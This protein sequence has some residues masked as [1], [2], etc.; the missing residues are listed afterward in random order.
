MTEASAD[1]FE[2]I[3]ADAEFVPI[4]EWPLL[5]AKPSELES[6]NHP[7]INVDRIQ[8]NELSIWLNLVTI[9]FKNQEELIFKTL[10]DQGTTLFI[11]KIDGEPVGAAMAYTN[12]S[13]TGIYHVSVPS[14]YQRKGVGSALFSACK[15]EAL[16]NGSV[17][18]VMQSSNQGLSTWKKMGMKHEGNLYLF[19]LPI[20]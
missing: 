18:L 4:A 11:A 10:L 9:N 17:S 13:I 6:F 8:K 16:A 12:N 2:T 20:A 19:M 1:A 7:G 15:N 3:L 5:K 14:K